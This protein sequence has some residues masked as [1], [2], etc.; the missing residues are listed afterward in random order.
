MIS[1]SIISELSNSSCNQAVPCRTKQQLVLKVLYLLVVWMLLLFFC[2]FFLI[3][4]K[5]IACHAKFLVTFL[6]IIILTQN[7]ILKNPQNSGC[8]YTNWRKHMQFLQ[9]AQAKQTSHLQLDKE[10]KEG[11]SAPRNQPNSSHPLL[12]S[13]R[14]WQGSFSFN[15]WNKTFSWIKFCYYKHVQYWVVLPGM[16]VIYI[17]ILPLSLFLGKL[18]LLSRLL[19]KE[20]GG[21]SEKI[22]ICSIAF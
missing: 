8:T 5:M 13:Q 22:Y 17:F 11:A 1:G 6:S 4:M 14:I 12:L 16:A 2:F 20:E 21:K 10:R 9:C 19:C 3:R 18:T 15:F 7:T